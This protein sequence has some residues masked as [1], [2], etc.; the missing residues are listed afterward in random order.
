[1][2]SVDLDSMMP[3]CDEMRLFIQFSHLGVDLFVVLL[4]Q[5]GKEMHS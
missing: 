4:R 5:S 3:S 1:M 2:L